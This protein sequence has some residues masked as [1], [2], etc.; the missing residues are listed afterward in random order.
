MTVSSIMRAA[1]A[2]QLIVA[3]PLGGL[4]KDL[5]LGKKDNS[6]IKAFDQPQL[7]RF[8]STA[9]ELCPE[10]YPAFAV[11]GLAGLRIG[12]AIALRWD[13][14]DLVNKR[15]HVV[16]QIG[17]ETKSSD[18]RDVEMADALHATL[19]SL[20][21]HRRAEAFKLGTPLSPY[22]TFPEFG[23]RA[24]RAAADTV[25]KRI[26]RWTKRILKAAG[27][28]PHHTPH[29]LRHS[30][31]SILISKGTPIAYVQ[32]ALGHK[33]IKLTVDTYGSWLPVE[34]HGAVNA[35]LPVTKGAS[36]GNIE[37]PLASQKLGG[38]RS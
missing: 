14:L 31:A 12:E 3:N 10:V 30:F 28:P 6:K 22:A 21:A 16:E 2:V 27:L 15:V 34:A 35:L 19:T 18:E 13:N 7:V 32:Q 9:H 25:V 1:V 5:R 17:G 4:T 29:S 36:T 8:L 33:S 37:D 26:R 38:K 11:M 23:E 20:L 24:D